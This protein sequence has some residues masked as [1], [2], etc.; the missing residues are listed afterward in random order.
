MR[1]ST[2]FE[3][4]PSPEAD[5]LNLP[6]AFFMFTDTLLVFDHVTHK[7]KVLSHVHLD[8]DIEKSYQEAIRKIDDLVDRLNQPLPVSETSQPTNP[9]ERLFLQFLQKGFEESVRK[10][11][12]Y[13]TAGEVIQ[14]VLSQRLARPT[15]AAPFEI[16]R[17]L[18]TINPSPY[19]YL[20]GFPGFS[21]YRGF[22][23]NPGQGGRRHGDDPSS[24]R[25]PTPGQ[26]SGR[27]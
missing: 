1:Q 10:I 11:K 27:R 9:S 3:K 7:I 14:V 4:L 8:G 12:Q 26:N 16:Y 15:D 23:R 24:G 19:M 18:R 22:T 21:D 5:P 2:H 25:N 6:E 20:S 13:I 17:A